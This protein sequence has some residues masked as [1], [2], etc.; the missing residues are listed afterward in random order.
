MPPSEPSD[1]SSRSLS[2]VHGT[3]AIP[4]PYSFWRR[5]F[6][7]AGPAYLV[8]VGYMDPG[9]WATDIAAGSRFGY[10]LLW[11][12]LMSNIM[13]VLLQSLSARLG[14]V[15]G[16]DL[17]QASRAMF[18][19]QVSFV[20]WILAEIAIA[21]CDLAEVLGAA[22]G[23]QLLFG[24]PLLVGVFVTALDSLILLLL[25]S[26]GVRLM[27]AFIL[28]LV[29]TIGVCLGLEIVLSRPEWGPIAA[30]FVPRLPGEG[31]LYLAI[32]ILG[33]TV[34]PHNL[35]L[36]SALVQ[37]RRVARTPGGI[38]AGVRFNVVDSVVALNGAFFV[39]AALLVM[40]A[41]TFHR[42]GFHEVTDIQEAHSL[43]APIVG[44][45]W[46]PIAFAIAL[47]ASGQASTIT[48]TLAGQIV[49][50]G[51]VR[52]RMRPIARRMLTRAVA[53]VPAVATIALFGEES[54]G[55]L[56][57]L[58]QVVLALQLSFAVLPLVHVV[59]DRRWMG[60]YAIGPALQIAAW[61]TAL[62]I[63]SLNLA[64]AWEEISGWLGGAG[65]Y[66]WLVRLTAV[67]A[68]LGLAGLLGYVA[69]VP[70]WQ[71]FRGRP[72]LAPPGVHGAPTM[73]EVR[74]TRP[75]QLIAAAVDFTP[76]DTA[77][78]SHAVGLARASGRGTRVLLLHVVESGG[79][80]V[81][82]DDLS[83]S[84][85]MS[86]RE[87]LGMYATELG[88]LGVDADVDLGHGVPADELAA[89]VGRHRPDLI[90][91]GSH[92]HRGLGD[93][94]HGTSIERLRHKISI[95]I[96]VVPMGPAPRQ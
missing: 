48:G 30:G 19:R 47:I 2:E 5:L 67:P 42:A 26:R 54:T 46:A 71:R 41:A 27:E 38:R 43:L 34:M 82:G 61:A 18:G 1:P 17:A 69:I 92:G 96:F 83:D 3:V 58:S 78:L 55:D 66:V 87:Q 22:I 13:A 86:D 6:A 35:Y 33:A 74:P 93:L 15:A 31:A 63:A 88:E 90:I 37:S 65:S 52:I 60:R 16:V 85:T 12:L 57:V 50:E 32:G 95:P 53:I 80:R 84:E 40:A 7:F 62:V 39:N 28:T 8:S 25:H 9:N 73:P 70:A 29:I 94:V 75:P 64:L 77:V 59:S 10:A 49:M 68:A 81:I 20:L 23:L 4:P 45:A 76:A 21:A 56:L 51:F 91:V 79:A 36:H 14:I 11:V 44:S 24:L 89:L 72:A